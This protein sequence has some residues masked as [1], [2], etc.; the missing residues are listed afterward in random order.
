MRHSS[1]KKTKMTKKR[2][3]IASQDESVV[4]RQVFIVLAEDGT[5]AIRTYLRRKGSRDPF[6]VDSVR[7]LSVNMSFAERFYLTTDLERKRLERTGIVGTEPE[8]IAS[9][10]KSFFSKR[11]DLGDLYL[12]YMDTEDERLLTDE[13]FEFISLKQEPDEHGLVALDIDAIDVIA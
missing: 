7:D 5:Q 2:F 3:L 6:F 12:K 8:I 13:L 1:Q 10:V 9:R 4:R 11:S